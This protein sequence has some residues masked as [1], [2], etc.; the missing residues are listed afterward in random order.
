MRNYYPAFAIRLAYE[1]RLTYT[2]QGKYPQETN[3]RSYKI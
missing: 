3:I 2:P 1:M